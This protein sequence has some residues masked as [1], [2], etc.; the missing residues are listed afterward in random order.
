MQALKFETR[1]THRGTVRLP[2]LRYKKGTPVEIIVLVREA[3][4]EFAELIRAAETSLEFWD[5]PIDDEVWN[6]A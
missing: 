2:R 1:V 3:E 5:N 4:D 6:D